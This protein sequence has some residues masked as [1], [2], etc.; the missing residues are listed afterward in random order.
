MLPLARSRLS[1]VAAAEVIAV[2]ERGH[3]DL[4]HTVWRKLQSSSGFARLLDHGVLRASVLPG[5][6]VRLHGTCYVGRAVAGD[7]VVELREKV[8]GALASLLVHATHDAFKVE[9]LTAPASDLGDLI[10]LLIRH[11]LSSVTAYA[12]R[13]RGFRYVAEKKRGSLA[14]GRLDITKTVQLRARGLGHVLAFEKS[15]V[16]FDTPVNRVVL[17]ALREV[18]RLTGV[19]RLSQDDAVR[20]RGLAMLFSDC[21]DADIVFGRRL[22]LV[23]QAHALLQT[24]LSSAVRDMVALASVVLAHESFEH[25]ESTGRSTP[26]SWFLNLEVLFET[27][28]RSVLADLLS[29]SHRVTTAADYRRRVF[30]AVVGEYGAHPDLVVSRELRVEAIGDVKYKTWDGKPSEDDIYQLLVHSA[31]FD[32]PKAFLVYPSNTFE[33]RSL[34]KAVTGGS[35]ASFAVDVRT[36]RRDLGRVVRE[37]GLADPAA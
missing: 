9:R 2:P 30:G 5:G 29:H 37:M 15:A 21:R 19:V 1:D 11:F 32:A 8:P 7:I 4:S 3:A 33:M 28:V 34:G 14:G 36:L 25:S 10:G 6:G 23:D 27:A 26:R 13:G 31:A 18:E 16:A 17:A 24:P 12:S 22:A 35:V 20:A